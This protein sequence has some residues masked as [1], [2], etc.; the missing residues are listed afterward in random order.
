M[1]MEK[2]AELLDVD[3][4]SIMHG[5]RG[6]GLSV[7]LGGHVLSATLDHDELKKS[8]DGRARPKMHGVAEKLSY[9]ADTLNHGVSRR[10]M[11]SMPPLPAVETRYV[12]RPEYQDLERQV[13]RF[14]EDPRPVPPPPTV[15]EPAVSTNMASRFHAIVAELNSP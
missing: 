10:A 12:P 3:E 2:L 15:A 4:V 5:P 13:Q 1:N 8:V 14:A 11:A 9:L 6:Y 7:S